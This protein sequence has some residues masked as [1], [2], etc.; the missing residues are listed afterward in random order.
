[1]EAVHLLPQAT[2][3]TWRQT[4]KVTQVNTRSAALAPRLLAQCSLGSPG[5]SPPLTTFLYLLVWPSWSLLTLPLSSIDYPCFPLSLPPCSYRAGCFRLVAQ[6][7][8]HLLTL[9]PH[10]RIF[11]TLKMVA[12]RSSETSVHSRSTRRHMQKTAF[13]HKQVALYKKEIKYYRVLRSGI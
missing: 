12:T 5:F 10:S 7:A 1:M 2:S 4:Y 13:L 11:L 3:C 8:S 9:V 6:S